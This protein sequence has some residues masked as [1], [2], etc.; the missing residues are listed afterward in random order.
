[1]IS[2]FILCCGRISGPRHALSLVVAGLQT[3][4]FSFV[5]PGFSPALLLAQASACALFP[6]IFKP[7]RSGG[8]RVSVSRSS[9]PLF[10]SVVVAGLQ[11]GSFLRSVISS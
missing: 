4:S 1:M 10:L 2:L 9:P 3:G 11:A 5:V 8:F 7:S 6:S